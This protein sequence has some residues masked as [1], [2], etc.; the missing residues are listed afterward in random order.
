MICRKEL[1]N[2]RGSR[3]SFSDA[4]HATSPDEALVPTEAGPTCP[5]S[6]GLA[7]RRAPRSW[8]AVIREIVCWDQQHAWLERQT[9]WLPCFRQQPP[10]RG[11]GIHT[12]VQGPGPLGWHECPPPTSSTAVRTYEPALTDGWGEATDRAAVACRR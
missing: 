1:A 5:A 2:S 8:A 9:T 7:W 12:S 4:F 3:R 6:Q 11:R 10:Y